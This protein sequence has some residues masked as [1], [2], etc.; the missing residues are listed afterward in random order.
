VAKKKSPRKLN[1]LIL[2]LSATLL[3]LILGFFVF[4]QK[5]KTPSWKT[6]TDNSKFSFSYR[7]NIEITNNG[8]AIK[9][10]YWP[11]EGEDFGQAFDASIVVTPNSKNLSLEDYVLQEIC[12]K[13]YLV[14]GKNKAEKDFLTSIVNS[15]VNSFAKSK[16]S[17]TLANI[18]GLS[19]D[20]VLGEDP[21]I[22]SIIEKS[23][24]FYIF[25]LDEPETGGYPSKERTILFDQILSTFKFTN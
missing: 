5:E 10:Y 18:A 3:V 24:N 16:K 17:I 8:N 23:N 7:P 4:G 6:Y 22:V 15:C 20:I 11:K 13:A 19:G 1:R 9:L 21:M 14:E 25:Y 2:I 12:R